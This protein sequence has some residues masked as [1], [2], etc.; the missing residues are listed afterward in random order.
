MRFSAPNVVD[1]RAEGEDARFAALPRG[2]W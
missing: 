2:A 1:V